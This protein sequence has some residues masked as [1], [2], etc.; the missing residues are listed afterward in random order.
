MNNFKKTI[1]KWLDVSNERIKIQRFYASLAISSFAVASVV[2]LFENELGRK[3]LMIAV[4]SSVIFLEN[5]IIWVLGVALF[6]NFFAA[7]TTK[8]KK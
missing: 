4:A 6:E 3:I 7:K 8:G 2:S 1:S 5:A